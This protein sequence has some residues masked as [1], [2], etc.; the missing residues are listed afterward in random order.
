MASKYALITKFKNHW[1][2]HYSMNLG[3]TKEDIVEFIKD[4]NIING[5][6]GNPYSDI[7]IS[8]MLYNADLKNSGSKNKNKKFLVSKEEFGKR[9]YWFDP[10]YTKR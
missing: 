2:D 10:R 4:N 6:S 9:V 3:F 8:A 1:L 7:T 5:K